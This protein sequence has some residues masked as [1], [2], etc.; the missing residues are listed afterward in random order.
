[1]GTRVLINGHWYKGSISLPPSEL[2]D[3]EECEEVDAKDE[4]H[5][6][7]CPVIERAYPEAKAGE[8]RWLTDYKRLPSVMDVIEFTIDPRT[9]GT[10]YPR[11]NVDG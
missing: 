7:P 2:P 4:W 5:V 8:H 1:L 6:V 3:G 11:C 9:G 10:V